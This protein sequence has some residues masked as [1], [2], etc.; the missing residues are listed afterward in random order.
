MVEEISHLK[1]STLTISKFKANNQHVKLHRIHFRYS[2]I[3]CYQRYNHTLLIQKPYNNYNFLYDEIHQ[4]ALLMVNLF[5][6]K[7]IDIQHY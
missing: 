3:F 1:C 4:F 6:V 7:N 5:N 2:F